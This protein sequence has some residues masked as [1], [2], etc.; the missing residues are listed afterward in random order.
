M[1][2]F[3]VMVI[4]SYT[5]CMNI[6]VK[7]TPAIKPKT[8]DAQKIAYFYAILLT[9]FALGQLFAFNDFITLLDSFW[10][11]GGITMA[12]L[13]AGVVVACEV[14][15]IPFLIGMS[16]SPLMRIAS[17]VL[18]W[19]VPVLWLFVS[20]WVNHSIN[21][22][23]N[24]GFLGTKVSLLPGPW[25]YFVCLSFGILAAWASWGMWPFRRK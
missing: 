12:T 3:V 2:T 22:I 11:P 4:W 24:I 5:S 10:L 16:L 14:F 6:F 20:I 19:L 7:A 15:A 18:G 9:I 13:L 1:T 8:P 25:T 21:A 17:M 23:T